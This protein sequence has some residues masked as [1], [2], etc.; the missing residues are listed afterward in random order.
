[1]MHVYYIDATLFIDSP[2]NNTS[3]KNERILYPCYFNAALMRQEGRRVSRSRAV[4]EPTLADIEKAAKKSG[5]TCRP[6][7]KHHPAYWWKKEGRLVVNWD[8]SKEQLLK[9]IAAR[10]ERK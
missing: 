1:M 2:S 8:K 4:K 9:T 5:L 6:E 10:L 7:Q 3:M